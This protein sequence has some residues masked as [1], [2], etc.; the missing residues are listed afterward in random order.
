MK[1]NKQDT[2]EKVYYFG[3]KLLNIVLVGCLIFIIVEVFK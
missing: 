3:E 1:N 2:D